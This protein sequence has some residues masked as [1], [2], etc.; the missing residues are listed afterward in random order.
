MLVRWLRRSGAA[1][2]RTK[3]LTV[4]TAQ[5]ITPQTQSFSLLTRIADVIL[6]VI[7]AAA[8]GLG[9]SYA[10]D[11][12]R[13]SD[14]GAPSSHA[15]GFSTQ[16]YAE[17]SAPG[18]SLRRTT[19]VGM[20]HRRSRQRPRASRRRTTPLRTTEDFIITSEPQLE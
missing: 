17:L 6:A 12:L 16:S 20:L 9:A 3:E 19:P 7:L 10:I 5:T 15:D 4:N 13:T 1:A 2:D 14:A 18:A 11:Q 8:V